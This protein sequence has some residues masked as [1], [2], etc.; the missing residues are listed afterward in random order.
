MFST[1][2]SKLKDMGTIKR[3]CD[4]AEAHALE[5]GKREPGA[6]HFL[7]AALD[8]PDGTA[9]LAFERIGADPAS[10]EPA[11]RAQYGEALRSLG[12][13]PVIET[14][15]DPPAANTGIYRAAPSG[16]DVM[17]ALTEGR[18]SHA[19]LLGAHVV[20]VVAGFP[21]GV[22]ARALRGM[23]VDRDALKASAERIASAAAEV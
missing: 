11:I 19:P 22:A 12:I 10:F 18:A 16:Q 4:G 2:R 5:D 17:R 6:E 15:Q 13:E 9:R 8:L 20:A 14:R 21:L 1:V 3:L 23:G 7:L